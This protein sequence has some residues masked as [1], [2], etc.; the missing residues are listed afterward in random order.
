MARMV[1]VPASVVNGFVHIELSF[2]IEK[3]YRNRCSLALTNACVGAYYTHRP[4]TV[5]REKDVSSSHY[6]PAELY[7]RRLAT[8]RQYRARAEACESIGDVASALYNLDRA[9]E[10]EDLARRESRAAL[11][12]AGA[13]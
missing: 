6:D 7:A 11:A 5:G 2:S 3:I 1:C 12:K 4:H 10:I 13:V 9:S 8:A